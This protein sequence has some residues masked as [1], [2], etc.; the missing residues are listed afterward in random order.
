MDLVL[1]NLEGLI[2]HKT[3]QTKPKNIFCELFEYECVVYFPSNIQVTD[4][5]CCK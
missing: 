4:N 2:C 5:F 3:Q 1:N